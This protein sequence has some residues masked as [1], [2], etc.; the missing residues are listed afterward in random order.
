[1]FGTTYAP[2]A[3]RPKKTDPRR[4]IRASRR[5]RSRSWRMARAASPLETRKQDGADRVGGPDDEVLHTVA[6]RDERRDV[7]GE[8]ARELGDDARPFRRVGL[9]QPELIQRRGGEEDRAGE[10]DDR[11]NRL[12]QRGG[13]RERRDREEGRADR[14]QCADPAVVAP[15]RFEVDAQP[16]CGCGAQGPAAP[17]TRPAAAS[18]AAPWRMSCSETSTSLSPKA[19]ITSIRIT[20]PATIVGARSGWMPVICR[21]S[22]GGIA[23][24]RRKLP[25]E[26]HRSSG[27]GH[28]PASCHMDPA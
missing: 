8:R 21:R 25:A 16:Q 15:L 24:E 14:E 3:E 1:M 23:G 7:E 9:R 6:D 4:L 28:A 10:V 26:R 17:G 22:A 18:S 20:T 5:A 11:V 12:R 19:R 27:G 2:M 13:T